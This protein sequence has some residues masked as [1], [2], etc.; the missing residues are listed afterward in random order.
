MT[1]QTAQLTARAK[2]RVGV[3]SVT[4][5]VDDFYQGSVPAL[6]PLFAAERGYSGLATGGLMFAG[7]FLSSLLQPG[8]GL[9]TDRLRMPW[10]VWVGM[11][12]AGVGIAASGVIDQYLYTW[13][14]ITLAGIGVAA[15][16]PEGARATREA[17]G[18]SAQ[19]MSWFSV[20]GN[21]GIA[22]APVLITPL[23][24]TTGLGAT[25]LL[26]VPG[27]LLAGG[28]LSWTLRG[29]GDQTRP[30][31]LATP[32]HST[33]ASAT[34]ARANDWR[35]FS[36]LLVV[37]IMRSI[38]YVGVSTFFVLY[39]VGRFG[40]SAAAAAPALTVFTGTGA[41]GTILGG[42]L[43]DRY[44]RTIII[45]L[46]YAT[47]IAGLV[48]I[49][50]APTVPLAYLAAV[51]SG[52]GLYLPFA[53]HTTLG[54]DYLPQKLATASGMTTGFAISAGGILAPVLGTFADTH[55]RHAVFLV[56]IA[57]PVI[58]LLASLPLTDVPTGDNDE[59]TTPT[60]RSTQ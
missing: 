59:H 22:V 43:A 45:R 24:S 58:A 47:A 32:P 4:H 21:I 60:N 20:G 53:V 40:L 2:R 35:S 31:Q 19:A 39:L 10:L 14:A 1:L 23:L 11:L 48:L 38:A 27:A 54:Q 51:V 25:P 29:R 13:L 6:V 34:P 26:I 44:G 52:L 37:V 49:A 18:G 36:W 30:H 3:L 33:P 55:G 50:L 12:V 7:T 42:W 15:F 56:L 57:A 41:C 28:F 46:G 5:F 9:L 8:F 16:H 17:A